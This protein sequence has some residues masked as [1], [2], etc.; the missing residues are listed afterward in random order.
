MKFEE[1]RCEREKTSSACRFYCS[2]YWGLRTQ[3]RD[4]YGPKKKTK[5]KKMLTTLGSAINS[6]ILKAKTYG[7]SKTPCN[8]IL[9][10]PT[11][12]F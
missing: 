11:V 10:I 3:L 8:L 7:N 5:N 1:T 12:L 2:L 9:F 6:K 4:N